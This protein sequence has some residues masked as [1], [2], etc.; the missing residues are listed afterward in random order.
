MTAAI[1]T[2]GLTKRYGRVTGIEDLNLTV[3]VGEVFGY[4]GPNGAGKTTTIRTL[5]DFIRPTS[6]RATVLGHDTRSD[7]L[8]IRRR[9]TYLP[10]ELTLYDGMTGGELATYFANLRGSPEAAKDADGI[11]ERLGLDLTRRIKQLSKGN[12]QKVGLVLAF[13]DRPQLIVLDEPTGGLDPLVQQQF[14]E[15][16]TEVRA[17]G[18]TIFISSHNLA[19]VE[20]VCDRVAII[21]DGHLLNVQPVHELKARAL[22]RLEIDFA[23]PVSAADFAGLPGVRDVRITG[24]VLRCTVIGSLDAVVKAAAR[25]E[26]RNVVS[27][28]PSLEEIVLAYYTGTENGPEVRDAA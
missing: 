14:Y 1:E 19:E 23:G 3:D 21:R 7:G 20:R 27:E 12:K 2:I 22:R 9:V 6:G 18:R 11:A 8:E 5:L 17:D 15:L 28:E 4:L 10:G 24:T 16:V 26:V 13:M 25:Y